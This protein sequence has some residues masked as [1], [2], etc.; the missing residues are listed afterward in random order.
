MSAC[1]YIT[2]NGDQAAII[3]ELPVGIADPVECLEAIKAQMQEMKG[4]HQIE[5]SAALFNLADVAPPMMFAA[6]LRSEAS[7]SVE[8]VG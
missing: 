5:A 2:R 1:G 8:R 3:A 7:H 4:S 6:A